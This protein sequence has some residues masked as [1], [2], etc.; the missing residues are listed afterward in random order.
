MMQE[1]KL[2]KAVRPAQSP[3]DLNAGK[4]DPKEALLNSGVTALFLITATVGALIFVIFLPSRGDSIAFWEY[5]FIGYGKMIG[6][7][8]G[9]SFAI[10]GALNAR[11]YSSVTKEGWASYYRRLEDWH[12]AM[13]EAF[14]NTGGQE[15]V[16]QISSYSIDPKIPA[17]TLAVAL[18]VHQA[19]EASGNKTARGYAYSTRGLNGSQFFRTSNGLLLA[20]ELFGTKPEELN[21]LFVELGLITNQKPGY[22]G[23]WACRSIEEVMSKVLNNW[24]RLGK[25]YTVG[26][27]RDD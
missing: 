1:T 17:H 22:A 3:M 7:L 16:T 11:L 23:E 25:A 18:A 14:D 5:N 20:G 24:Y 10:F 21:R 26:A 12:N 2:I 8:T 9:L 4:P 15:S 19:L 6:L 13:L 27:V